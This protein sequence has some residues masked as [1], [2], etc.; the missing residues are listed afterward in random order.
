[1]DMA[2]IIGYITGL[3]AV[4][5]I[6]IGLGEMGTFIEPQSMAIVVGGGLAAALISVPMEHATSMFSVLKHAF[7]YKNQ[8]PVDL[9]KH[10]VEYAEV[11][12]RDG[13]LA[14][15]NVTEGMTDEFLK[16]G[17][18]LA[19]DGTDPELIDQIMNTELE[20]IEARHMDG[21]K[22]FDLMSKYTPAWGM[23]GTLIGLINMLKAGMEDPNALSLGMAIALITTFYGAVIANYLVGPISDKLEI[24]NAQEMAL[25]QIIL[26]G[27]MSIQSGDNPRIVEQKLKIYLAPKDRNFGKDQE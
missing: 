3:I 24:R 19:V 21:K 7:I 1:M 16:K 6:G 14:L 20:N 4:V 27:V 23:I 13:I 15:E 5:F 22:V 10:M 12:R 8:S 18:Q 17:V 9:I 25:K 11:A 2:T 26:R